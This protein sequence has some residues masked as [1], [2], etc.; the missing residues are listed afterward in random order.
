MSTGCWKNKRK[1]W[2]PISMENFGTF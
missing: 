1:A 2:T